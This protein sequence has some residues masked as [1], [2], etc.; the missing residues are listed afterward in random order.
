MA[1]AKITSEHLNNSLNMMRDK[2]S[3]ELGE[4][5]ELA[6]DESP[7]QL[8][9]R[10][11]TSINAGC[12]APGRMLAPQEETLIT[13]AP[14]EPEA[15]SRPQLL[16]FAMKELLVAHRSLKQSQCKTAERLAAQETIASI[17]TLVAAMERTSEL[18]ADPLKKV[19]R[20][21]FKGHLLDFQQALEHAYP[22]HDA[23]SRESVESTPSDR[24]KLI[25]KRARL[26]LVKLFTDLEIVEMVDDG[27]KGTPAE[28][29]QRVYR[30]RTRAKK[31]ADGEDP[32]S[33]L[34]GEPQVLIL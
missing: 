11:F 18:L 13:F 14:W 16:A 6:E 23:P 30:E 5:W 27:L 26:T 34:T 10:Y 31:G 22:Q 19:E 28:R 21:N 25:T 32:V 17:S 2:L 7:A 8:L 1:K 9:G 33:L 24:L 20:I 12:F 15:G 4:D 3:K 29:A